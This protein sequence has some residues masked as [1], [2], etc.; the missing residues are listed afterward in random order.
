MY[1]IFREILWICARDITKDIVN[2]RIVEVGRR[3]NGKK[4]LRIC[5]Q[6]VR[7]VS[8]EHTRTLDRYIGQIC[9]LLITDTNPKWHSI[10]PTYVYMDKVKHT[11][12]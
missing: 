6:L 7:Y 2:K 10:S 12:E 9:G 8:T 5:P 4:V 1:T 11:R 3:F